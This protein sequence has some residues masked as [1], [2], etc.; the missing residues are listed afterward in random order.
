[1]MA[2]TKKKLP[3]SSYAFPAERKEPLSDAKHVRNALA[4]F[5]QVEGVT[6]AERDKAW[7]RILTAAKKF[8]V[9]VSAKDWRELFKDKKDKK[10]KKK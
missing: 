5:D 4:R 10:A 9:E 7:R 3:D 8:D 1:M 2:T 6:D